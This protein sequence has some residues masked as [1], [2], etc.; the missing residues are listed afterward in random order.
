MAPEKT[1]TPSMIG[2]NPTTNNKIFFGW[3]VAIAA[4]LLNLFQG[5]VL[6]YGFTVVILPLTEE[7]GWSRTVVTGVFPIIGILAGILAP[8]LGNI[9]DRVGPRPIIAVGLTAMGAGLVLVSN[10]TTL[11]TFYAAFTLANLG[12]VCIWSSSGPA[13]ANWFVKKQGRALGLYSLGFAL[14]GIM[15]PPFFWLVQEVGWR[16]A[17]MYVGVIAW[18]LIPFAMFFIRHRPE[19]YGLYPDGSDSPPL[20]VGNADMEHDDEGEL[21]LSP[22]QAIRTQAFWLMAIGSSLAFLTIAALQV[23]WAPYLEDVGYSRQAAALLLPAMP[24]STVIGRILFGFL[25]DKFNKKLIASVAFVLQSIAILILAMISADKPWILVL[26]LCFWSIGFGGTIVTRLA[27]QGY[28]FGRYSFGTLQGL[29]SMSSEAGFAFS[30]LIASIV[31]DLTGSY[32]PLFFGFAAL[33]LLAAPIT[34]LIK[35]PQPILTSK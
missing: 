22:S 19:N 2:N 18:I 33:T 32:S 21:N 26:F 20:Q 35:R 17:F 31:F 4:V 30:P 24:L 14:S 25:A 12:S 8:F 15:S 16:T 13:V 1:G 23:H 7:T 27:L 9:F 10:V 11:P 28:L 6:F 5:G 34:M 29:F 3:W